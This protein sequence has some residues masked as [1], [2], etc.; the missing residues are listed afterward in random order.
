MEYLVGMAVGIVGGRLE[1][2][3]DRVGSFDPNCHSALRTLSAG[4]GTSF[5]TGALSLW[6]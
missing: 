1:G 5:I 3:I 6:K 2:T 4:I